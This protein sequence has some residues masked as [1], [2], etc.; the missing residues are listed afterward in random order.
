METKVYGNPCLTRTAIQ[1]NEI[2]GFEVTPLTVVYRD[3]GKATLSRTCR[4][5]GG[6]FL[7]E[8][9]DGAAVRRLL[10]STDCPHIQD[11]LPTVPPDQREL[12]FMS[13]LCGRCWNEIMTP[14]DKEDQVHTYLV[15]V[16][17]WDEDNPRT[18]K[19][20]IDLTVERETSEGLHEFVGT[21]LAEDTSLDDMSF[22]AHEIVRLERVS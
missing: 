2:L 5:C 22:L 20:T 15:T 4:H 17:V 13:G 3:D 6:Q 19:R 16:E 7:A 8:I 9:D 14:P 12:F 11:I 21:I 1:M 10:E 18:P